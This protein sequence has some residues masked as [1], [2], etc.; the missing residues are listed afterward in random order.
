MQ[1]KNIVFLD[2]KFI[3]EE[4]ARISVFEPGFLYGWGIFETMRSYRGKIIYLDAH[5][6]RLEALAKLIDLAL[7]WP[8]NKLK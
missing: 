5:L 7:P 1:G 2:R 3:P 6:K 4:E 8:K